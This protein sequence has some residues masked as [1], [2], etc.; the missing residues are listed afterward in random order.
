MDSSLFSPLDGQKVDSPLDGQ[1]VDSS[2]SS[3][4]DGQKVDSVLSSPLD[5]QKVDSSLSSPL[6]GQRVESFLLRC[7]T[8]PTHN[9]IAFLWHG[10]E[11]AVGDVLNS[12]GVQ[13]AHHVEVQQALACLWNAT[14]PPS[15]A[16]SSNLFWLTPSSSDN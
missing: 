3:P 4:L 9:V 12:L 16:H 2:L 14:S 6:D 10:D 5:G 11:E 1:K 13:L 8:K 7:V 15:S